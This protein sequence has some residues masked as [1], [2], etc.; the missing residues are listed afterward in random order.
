M[1]RR[2]LLRMAACL[3]AVFALAL[4]A[5][6]DEPSMCAMQTRSPDLQPQMSPEAKQRC[7]EVLTP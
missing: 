1:T 7:A 3:L 4:V 5:F 6:Q 2:E